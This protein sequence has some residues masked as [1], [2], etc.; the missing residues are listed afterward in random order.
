MH[1]TT[2]LQITF[3]A[4]QLRLELISAIAAGINPFLK[5]RNQMTKKFFH[6]LSAALL[7]A[8]LAAPLALPAQD[9]DDHHDRDDH[10]RQR[11]YDRE[12]K[13]YH[14]WND[15]ENRR[16]RQWYS[17]THRGKDF[18]DYHKLKH[19]DRDDYWNWR[20]NHHDDDDHR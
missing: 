3:G 16:Y 18:H 10:D 8:A 7:V 5:G 15:D 2:G 6:Y 17:E 20:H 4:R 9:R 1:P 13:D 14:Q 12:H 11:I 19:K